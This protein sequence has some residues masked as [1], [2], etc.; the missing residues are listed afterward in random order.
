M[1]ASRYSRREELNMILTLK[2]LE[3]K[4]RGCWTG[5]AI[6]GTLGMPFECYRQV[7]D[8]SFYV[9]DLQKKSS[10]NDDLDLQ[11]VWLNA[12]ERYGKFVNAAILGEYWIN[13]IIPEWVEYGAAK[14]NL[15][16]G[17]I[18]PL[19]G[20]MNNI[21][22]DSNGAWIRSEIWACIAPGHPEIAARYAYED[23]IVDHSQEGLYGEIFCSVIESSAF[24]EK[25]KNKLIDIGLSY[26]PAD[27]GVAKGVQIVRESFKKGL[28]WQEA[29]KNLLS[30][31]PGSTGLWHTTRD[32]L[33]KDLPVGKV[34]YDAPGDIGIFII[35]WLYGKDDFGKSLCIAVNCGE[36]ADC[37]GA[38]LGS[39]LGIINGINGIPAKWREPIGEGIQTA[40]INLSVE[41]GLRVP[42]TISELTERIQRVTPLFLGSEYCDLLGEKDGYTIRAFEGE[43][44]FDRIIY[45]KG[46]Y[47]ENINVGEKFTDLL[48]RSPFVVSYRYH[49]FNILLDYCDEPYIAENVAKKF[50]LSIENNY[51]LPQWINISWHLPETWTI[52]PGRNQSVYLEHDFL[53]HSAELAFLITADKLTADSYDLFVAIG[54]NGRHTKAIIPIRLIRRPC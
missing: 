45:K 46:H 34:G 14:T 49:L 21:F 32:K 26:I 52:S 12:I 41:D 2:D 31:V 1:C 15:R 30:V 38:T 48:K 23:A 44:L 16:M 36:D 28:L 13:F 53:A 27:C 47:T 51:S 4:I 25:D 24:V 37:T 54:A 40:F 8:V 5:K 9:Q 43:D 7:N 35:G 19:S 42:K 18:P 20:H 3:E 6:G 29:R 17:I 10:A 50:V 11:L 39:I 33:P 22:R